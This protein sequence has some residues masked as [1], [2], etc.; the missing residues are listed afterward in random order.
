MNASK[1]RKVTKCNEKVSSAGKVGEKTSKPLESCI[2]SKC[3][4]RFELMEKMT[5]NDK[6]AVCC[7]DTCYTRAQTVSDKIRIM[8]CEPYTL[9]S[10]PK[11]GNQYSQ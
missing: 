1:Y 7:E 9:I 11:P 3:H 10:I 6:N 2:E 8:F 4:G 5:K